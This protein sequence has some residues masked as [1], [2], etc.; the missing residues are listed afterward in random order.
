MA[1]YTEKYQAGDSYTD[2]KQDSPYSLDDPVRLAAAVIKELHSVKAQV[3]PQEVVD[4]L[5][6]LTQKPLD[7]KTG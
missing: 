3:S 6:S 7:D 2:E 5:K 1:F 4:I